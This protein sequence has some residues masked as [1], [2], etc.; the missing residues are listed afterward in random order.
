MVRRILC[1]V[2]ALFV[3]G[4]GAAR[5]EYHD[6]LIRLHVLAESDSEADQAFKLRVRD[7]VLAYAQELLKDC[8]SA[9]EAYTLIRENEEG[10]QRAAQAVA[11]KEGNTAEIHVETG[12]FAF[13][14][15]EYDGVLV[16]AGDYR[17]L[18]V[19]IGSGA[20]HNWWCV[21]YPTLCVPDAATEDV[22]YYSAVVEWL[23]GVFG[24]D[25]Q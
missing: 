2:A 6:E 20:G 18:R 8:E 19:T 10:F 13:P 15:R 14:D 24:G 9:D 25:A 17:A 7:G 23:M 1:G 3:L 11:D 4:M 16:P 21:L 5:A 12:V 22:T